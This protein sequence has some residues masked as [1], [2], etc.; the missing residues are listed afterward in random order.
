M[1]TNTKKGTNIVLIVRAR[2]KEY[3]RCLCLHV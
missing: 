2:R 1:F 3:W